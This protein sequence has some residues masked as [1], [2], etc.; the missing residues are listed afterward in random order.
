MLDNENADVPELPILVS[1]EHKLSS[2][3]ITALE[4]NS[5]LKS[6]PLGKAVGPDGINNRVLRELANELADSLSIFYNLS[7]QNSKVPDDWKEAHVCPIHKGGDP[8]LV[9][10]YRPVSLLNTL[11]KVFERCIFKHIYN[12]FRDNDILSPL[13]SGF[14]PGDS[15]V[16]QLTYLYDTFCHALDS[17]K[18]VRVVF[19]D[20]SKAFDRVW[21]AGLIQKLKAAGIAGSLLNWFIDYLSN[22][23]QRVTFSGVKSY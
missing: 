16:N 7:L 3:N 17:G 8:V 13:Q 20:I 18:E 5:V 14:I 15:T 6:L 23:K 10:N 9:S 12:H 11:D 1:E 19:C 2:L 4:V 21:H 22:R